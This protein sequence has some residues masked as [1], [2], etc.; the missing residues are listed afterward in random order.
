[1]IKYLIAALALL[2]SSPASAEKLSNYEIDFG[3][4]KST[5]VRGRE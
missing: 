4:W 5:Y 3:K 2:A 1:M